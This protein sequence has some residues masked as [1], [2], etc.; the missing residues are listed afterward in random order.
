MTP[1]LLRDDVEQDLAGQRL[2]ATPELIERRGITSAG[3]LGKICYPGT[4][5]GPSPLPTRL[6]VKTYRALRRDGILLGY[7]TD[8]GICVARSAR[9]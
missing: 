4:V 9:V 3:Y 8:R 2:R 5:T 1:T 7:Q 6:V